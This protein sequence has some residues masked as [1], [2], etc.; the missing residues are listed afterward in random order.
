I[1]IFMLKEAARATYVFLSAIMLVISVVGIVNLYTSTHRAGTTQATYQGPT[2]AQTRTAL[3]K[4][5]HTYNNSLTPH[6]NEQIHRNIQRELN[7]LSGTPT[8]L[9]IKQY[10]SEGLI[11]FVAIV[12]LVIFTR[13]SIK[14]VF[15]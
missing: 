11:L 1:G 13:P 6:H 15:S 5:L 8:E 10:L 2:I 3:E 9:K 7:A 14:E 4:S 12:P